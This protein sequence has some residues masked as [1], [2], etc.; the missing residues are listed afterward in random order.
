MHNLKV[1]IYVS[2]DGQNWETKAWK[3]ASQVTL[4][5]CSKDVR[6][7][8]DYVGLCNKNQVARTSKDYC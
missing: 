2:F 6:K 3:T 8:P 7:K 5:D 1:E 4:R